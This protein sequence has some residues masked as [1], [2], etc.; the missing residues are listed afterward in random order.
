[1][2]HWNTIPQLP[3][4]RFESAPQVAERAAAMG[5]FNFGVAEFVIVTELTL[6]YCELKQ[7]DGLLGRE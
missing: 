5:G 4:R 3:T 7:F 2:S 6:D 1:M